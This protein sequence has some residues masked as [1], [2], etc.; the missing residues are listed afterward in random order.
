M[1]KKKHL[2]IGFGDIASRC[3]KVLIAQ[4]DEVVGVAR[5]PRSEEEG[6]SF[7]TG[8]AKNSEVLTCVASQ[9]FDSIVVT[10]SPNAFTEADYRECYYDT[11]KA[12]LSVLGKNRNSPDKVLFISSTSVYPQENGEV[13]DE[14]S[15]AEPVSPTAKVLRE[16]ENLFLESTLSV[17]IIRFSGIYG[18]GRDYLLRQVQQGSGGS[19]QYTNRIHIE[20]CCGVIC[21]LISQKVLHDMYLASDDCPVTS[22]EIRKWLAGGL[23][24]DCDVLTEPETAGRGGSKRCNNRRLKSEG[25]EFRYPDY[26]TGYSQEIVTFLESNKD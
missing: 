22:K 11:S 18:P 17:S 3:A 20:D 26:K 12:L 19:D 23:G 25:Y 1:T 2:F 24:I 14:E 5:T 9:K 7:I 6:L 10:L 4:G 15:L 16:T 21:F 13:V 8:D